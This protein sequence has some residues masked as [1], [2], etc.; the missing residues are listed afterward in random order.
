MASL[1]L[2]IDYKLIIEKPIVMSKKGIFNVIE[3]ISSLT[4]YSKK[5][6]FIIKKQL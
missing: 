1:L 2:I 3:K 5:E 6:S 4:P